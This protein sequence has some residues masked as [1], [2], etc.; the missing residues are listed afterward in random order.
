MELR[1]DQ[2]W[3]LHG[4]LPYFVR[5]FPAHEGHPAIWQ[6]GRAIRLPEYLGERMATHETRELYL[7]RYFGFLA[8]L[9]V[10]AWL[11]AAGG[12]KSYDLVSVKAVL[13]IQEGLFRAV[14]KVDF[15]LMRVSDGV[16]NQLQGVISTARST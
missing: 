9:Q 8:G 3:L 2:I 6:F 12:A 5:A 14:E 4:G 7:S 15:D 11:Y 1:D 10:P 16:I 13:P